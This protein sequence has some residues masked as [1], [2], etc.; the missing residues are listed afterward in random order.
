[1]KGPLTWNSLLVLLL[2]A[3]IVIK[4]VVDL[5]QHERERGLL[6]AGRAADTPLAVIQDGTT[7][8]QRCVHG[9]LDSLENLITEHGIRAPAIIVIGEVTALGPEL[10]WFGGQATVKDIWASA[11]YTGA[12]DSQREPK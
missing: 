3:L 6:A 10:E 8:A 5:R 4:T 12:T 2:I 1:M 9:R 7:P 11:A